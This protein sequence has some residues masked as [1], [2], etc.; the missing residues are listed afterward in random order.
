[1]PISVGDQIPDTVLFEMTGQGPAA[2]Q[3]RDVFAGRT[4]ALFAVPG[5]FTPTCT[6]NHLPAYV[7]AADA[8]KQKGVDAIVCMSVN[9]PFVLQAWGESVDGATAVRILS[10]GNASFTKALGLVLDGS[11]FGLGTRAQRF[12]MLVRDG[13]VRALHLEPDPSVVKVSGPDT[14]LEEDL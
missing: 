8:L 11:G 9:D 2:V 6:A 7:A 5:A 14:L 3:A 1:M 12:S 10:D 13:M 4:V